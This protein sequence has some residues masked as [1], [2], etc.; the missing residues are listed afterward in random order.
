MNEKAARLLDRVRD[1]L[2][3]YPM[4]DAGERCLLAVSGGPDS[5]CLVEVFRELGLPF[6]LAH[7]DHGTRGGESAEDAAF[8]RDRARA[9]GVPLHEERRDVPREAGDSPDSFEEVARRVRYRFLLDTA[10]AR[11]LAV[12]ATG[13][14]GDDQAETVLMRLLRGASPGGLGGIPP[15]REHQGVR[16]IRPL[17]ECFRED[18]LAFLDVRGVPYRLDRTNADL[19]HPRNRIR[20]EL[21]P[22][23]MG[24]Y[25]PRVREALVRLAEAQRDE[26]DFLDA[27]VED[28]FQACRRGENRIERESFRRL[29]PAL[30]RRVIALLGW[31]LGIECPYQ[32]IETIRRH[33]AEGPTGKACDMGEGVLLRNGRDMAEVMKEAVESEQSVV[34]L[35]VPGE[36]EA[37]GRRYRVRELPERPSKALAAYCTPSRQ[38][39][40]AEV[41]GGN[42]AVRFR[43]PGDRFTPLGLGGTKKL[44]DYF[45]DLGLTATQ[46]ARQPLLVAN[47]T[48]VWV[49]GHAVSQAA[50]VTPTTRRFVEVQVTDAPQ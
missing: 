17:L 9:L 32:R 21:L 50:A 18:I 16:I 1:T 22:R 42:L 5:M 14:H 7:L 38:V 20:H 30:Q 13:H 47:G 26:D 48:I 3:R 37:F 33:I 35:E 4:L 19:R 31:E 24:D 8:L 10:S 23:L 43:R 6:E 12:V 36:T 49:V 2:D 29:H 25:N 11:G 27:H 41:L 15:V 28:A 39:F 44:K 34:T 40:D 45:I 46:R